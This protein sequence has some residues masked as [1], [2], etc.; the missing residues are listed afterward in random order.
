MLHAIYQRLTGDRE[1]PHDD[2]LDAGGRAAIPHNFLSILV[3]YTASKLGDALV[4]PKTTLTWL[5]GAL[6]APAWMI[7]LL[8]PIR[9]SGSMVFQILI[10][11]R[12]QGARQ[13]K[14]VWMLGGLL[15]AGAVLG[16]ACAAFW[17][18]G[19][20]ASTLIVG[21]LGLFALARSLSSVASKDVLGRVLPKN[22]RGRVTGWAASAAGL[23]TLF[24]SSLVIWLNPDSL[25][26]GVLAAIL[27]TG[28]VM[29]LIAAIFSALV[30]EP[31]DPSG[32]Q[33][34]EQVA[35]SP[36]QR[37]GLLRTDRLLLQFV[38]ARALLLGSALS[39]PYFLVIA[40]AADGTSPQLLFAFV[41]ASG[42]AGMV[43]GPFWGQLA[44][45]SSRRVMLAGAVLSAALGL[46]VA[47]AVWSDAA[48]PGRAGP[49]AVA[50]FLLSVAHEGVRLGRKTYLVNVAEGPQRTDYVAVSNSVIGLLLLFAGALGAAMAS[51]SVAL[52]LTLLAAFSLLGTW[53]GARLPEAE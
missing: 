41:L 22:R 20:A 36:W 49:M 26:T 52:A 32:G 45:R 2:S 43:S 21:F 24:A 35:Q 5:L 40:Q 6:A 44:D 34:S 31:T 14:W 47:G 15:Q 12:V 10:A 53:L 48:W 27:V 39:A 25:S 9:E 33:Q 11:G 29:W 8:V 18:N 17:L 38:I 16:M 19:L 46:I 7:G 37:L 30:R 4:N 51:V 3:S 23:I 28:A 13:R 1:L 42:V 50:F